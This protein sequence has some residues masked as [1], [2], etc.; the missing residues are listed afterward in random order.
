MRL[1]RLARDESGISFVFVGV[2]MMAFLA[3]TTLAIDVG[4]FMTARTQA[5]ASA[6]AGALA[7]AV[8]LAFNSF[9]DRSAS[10]PAVQSAINAAKDNTVM[11]G[12]V[13]IAPAD[14]TFPND[15]SGQPDRVAVAVYRT[16]A[17]GNAVPTLMGALFGVRTVDIGA[18]ATAEAAPANAETCVMPF[19]IPD[20][21]VEHVDGTCTADGSW[22]TTST[23]DVA[24]T[25][26]NK[27]NTGAACSNPDVYVPPG[28]NGNTGYSVTTDIGLEIV[29]KS[30]NQNNVAPSMYNPWDLPGSTGGSDYE[31]NI[32]GC[33]TNIVQIGDMM[34]PENGNMVGPTQHGTDTLIAKDPNAYWDTSCNCVKGSAF[35]VSPRVAIVPLYNPAVYASG[36]QTG[37][38]GPQLQVAN[39]LGFFIEGVDGAGNVT[40][41]I[42]PVG[43]LVKGNGGPMAGAF[44]RAIRLVQ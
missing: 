9:T 10:G 7:G 35:G 41:R 20:K 44:P 36:Q 34:T 15:P 1:R 22:T 26:G 16:A 42:T 31:N 40:G 13:S 25:K 29:L 27:Q 33:N 19:T 14:V 37:K 11:A 24:A 21:W 2:G 39:Y 8:A 6:D 17:R 30:S 18:T 3:A 38:S 32:A 28:Q 23:F 5:Q 12:A 4:M 43:G